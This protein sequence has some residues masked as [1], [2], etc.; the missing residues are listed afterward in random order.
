MSFD[1]ETSKSS[2]RTASRGPWGENPEG[3]MVAGYG[4]FRRLSSAASDAQRLMLG[5][6]HISRLV[7][8]FRED[9][10]LSESVRWLQEIYL[11]RLEKREGSQELEDLVLEL[12]D[13]GLLPSEVR[14]KKVDSDGLW[15]EHQGVLL[16]LNQ[17][18]DG[19]RTVA[20]LVLDIVRHLSDAYG[21][22]ESHR[23]DSGLSLPYPGV[24]LIDEIDAH[25][26]VSWQQVIGFW[27]KTRFPQIQFIVST[28]S[29]FVCQA[30]D[31]Q[32]LIRLP[33]PG[34]QAVAEHVDSELF[35]RVV[36]GTADEATLTDLFGLEQTHSKQSEELRRSVAVLE[37]KIL[38]GDATKADQNSYDQLQLQLPRSSLTS[39]DRAA[40]CSSSR[41]AS[42]MVSIERVGIPAESAEYLDRKTA[43]IVSAGAPQRADLAKVAWRNKSGTRF[44]PIR[45]ALQ[46]M[47][48]GLE[49]C[50]YCEDSAG[51]HIDHFEPRARNPGRTFDWG[52]YLLACSVCNSNF[53]RNAFP[54]DDDGA[55]LL[56]DPTVDDPVEH[57]TLSPTTG[58]FEAAPGSV[59]GVESIQ[60]FGLNRELLQAARQN[61]WRTFEIAIAAYGAACERDDDSSARQIEATIRGLNCSAALQSIVRVA[62]TTE[63]PLVSDVTRTVIRARPEMWNW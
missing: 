26:H 33:A 20:A 48:S 51:A 32:G 9:A 61:A 39:V 5:A 16:P 38:R 25:L 31:A 28:H 62:R 35:L 27:L 49:R 13:D 29:P 14:V 4:P 7:S 17:L 22:L 54:V 57:L 1:Q 24:V 15:V 40:Q 10:S 41:S 59:K 56:I 11:R 47:C 6:G 18:S 43:E 23:S 34:E 60:A 63:L 42:R 55:P 36:N 44:G 52:N 45:D 21:T 19:Y 58:R 12:L 46:E 2:A 50:M 37:A 3:W 30:A 8:L 53:K